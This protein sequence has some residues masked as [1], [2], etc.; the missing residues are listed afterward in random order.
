ML[1]LG[2]LDLAGPRLHLPAQR[3]FVYRHR[4]KAR[5]ELK[6]LLLLRDLRL[7]GRGRLDEGDFGIGSD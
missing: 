3:R 2:D 4:A 7:V 5:G 6:V 1:K